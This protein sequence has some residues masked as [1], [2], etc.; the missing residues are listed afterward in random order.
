MGLHHACAADGLV[1]K[2][3]EC[4]VRRRRAAGG[5]IGRRWRRISTGRIVA[6]IH[7]DH[8]AALC[9]GGATLLLGRLGFR[10][11][12]GKARAEKVDEQPE[13]L[14]QH[15]VR[16]LLKHAE[17]DLLAADCTQHRCSRRRGRVLDRLVLVAVYEHKRRTEVG[18]G[19]VVG[20]KV[21]ELIPRLGDVTRVAKDAG[22]L[23][24]V[25]E[26]RGD[27]ER[28][29]VAKAADDDAIALDGE[30]RPQVVEALVHVLDRIAQALRSRRRL[31]FNHLGI[32]GK[33]RIC[34]LRRV[35]ELVELRR[36]AMDV[37]VW[38]VGLR[39][40]GKLGWVG[41]AVIVQPEDRAGWVLGCLCHLQR[42]ILQRDA[43]DR[44]GFDVLC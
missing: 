32:D 30:H 43:N 8:R 5:N 28:T 20:E 2:D 29:A 21:R 14:W 4:V 38:H 9:L 1:C 7:L 40:R 41:L 23:A 10:R 34:W 24:A 35:A 37:E 27:R 36:R 22:E 15:L 3:G 33:P 26:S 44:D 19:A 11:L 42:W 16:D 18:H 17:D 6:P 31:V 39:D 12:N 25:S 13:R